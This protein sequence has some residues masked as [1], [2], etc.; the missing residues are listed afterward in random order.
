MIF[1]FGPTAR[2]DAATDRI[3]FPVSLAAR[4]AKPSWHGT[5]TLQRSVLAQLLRRPV[6]VDRATAAFEAVRVIC[7]R[8]AERRIL[9]GTVDA[10]GMV[11]LTL[12]DIR[13][14]LAAD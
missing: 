9:A 10:E 3:T 11:H 7:E 14:K 1:S 4:S 2:F 8:A 5:A 6:P 13:A 12:G